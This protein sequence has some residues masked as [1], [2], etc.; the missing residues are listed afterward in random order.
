MCACVC[1]CVC[2][3]VYVCTQGVVC[4]FDQTIGLSG[5]QQTGANQAHKEKNRQYQT[6]KHEDIQL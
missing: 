3:C 1:V 4:V 6:S 2:V 5:I